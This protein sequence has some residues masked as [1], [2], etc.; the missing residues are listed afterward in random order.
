MDIRRIL[1]FVDEA[2]ARLAAR[3]YNRRL[4]WNALRGY[5]ADIDEGRQ[6]VEMVVYVGLPPLMAEWAEKREKTMRFL[7]WLRTNGFLVVTKDGSPGDGDRY[8]ANVDVM[9]ALDAL[10]FAVEARPDIVVLVTGDS[11]FAHLAHKLRRRGVRVEVAAIATSLSNDLRAAAN[12][13]IDLRPLFNRFDALHAEAAV[14]GG[15]DVFD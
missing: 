1:I 14:I 2:N 11:D 10:E 12:D 5:L 15:E 9:M 4:D 8:K 6:L 7:Y 13:V 3:S